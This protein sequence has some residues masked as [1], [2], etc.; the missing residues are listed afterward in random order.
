METALTRSL[1]SSLF[2]AVL[3][4]A[5][6]AF[7]ARPTRFGSVSRFRRAFPLLLCWS[8]P[9]VAI[10]YGFSPLTF[11]WVQNP[12]AL[13]VLYH[14]VVICRLGALAGLAFIYLPETV[15]PESR[16]VFAVSSECAGFP[17]SLSRKSRFFV[18]G[19]VGVRVSVVFLLVFLGAFGEFELA[20]ML[21]V[22]R[23]T[24]LAFDACAQGCSGVEIAG[25]YLV[26]C[27]IQSAVVAVVLCMLSVLVG[28]VARDGGRLLCLDEAGNVGG[29]AG[30]FRR[31]LS[32]VSAWVCLILVV[33]LP[34]AVISRGALKGFFGVLSSPWMFSEVAASILFAV[35]G[36]AC[37]WGVAVVATRVRS[38]KGKLLLLLCAFPGLLGALPLSLLALSIFQT[39][40]LVSLRDTPIPLV[41]VY[42]FLFLPYAL[43]A[44]FLSD[45]FADGESIHSARL[46]GDL[47]G[48]VRRWLFWD[49]KIQSFALMMGLVFAFAYFELTASAILSPSAMPTIATRLFNL[50]HYGESE[51]LSATILLV[52]LPPAALIA[53]LAAP[54]FFRR[55]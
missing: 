35:S 52:S 50:A 9:S 54:R 38:W 4:C 40:L 48:R 8:F 7:V 14:I 46:A 30:N 23:W 20:S 18:L 21:N 11:K 28:S 37:A 51:R 10:G 44:V 12:L 53:V 6:G 42:A 13:E 49:L 33:G 55:R 3:G 32:A 31:A 19:G 27:L 29:G 47:D 16:R 1:V 5:L 17:W 25:S 22:H 34:G 15:S 43:A 2:V 45:A 24:T 39:P 41:A 26:P 36:V